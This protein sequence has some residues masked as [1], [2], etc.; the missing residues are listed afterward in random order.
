MTFGRWR[1]RA[2]LAASLPLL[3]GGA[4]I[5]TVARQVGYATASAY[6][7]AFHREVGTTPAR[8]FGAGSHPPPGTEV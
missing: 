5:G 6:V 1:T 3:A 8:Y 7:S 2:R 4:G